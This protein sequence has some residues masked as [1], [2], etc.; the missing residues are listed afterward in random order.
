MISSAKGLLSALERLLRTVVDIMLGLRTFH[1]CY[2]SLLLLFV[3]F[4]QFQKLLVSGIILLLICLRIL[5]KN[6]CEKYRAIRAVMDGVGGVLAC[7]VY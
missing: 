4:L 1:Y 7:S 5:Q 3:Q 2:L 6:E